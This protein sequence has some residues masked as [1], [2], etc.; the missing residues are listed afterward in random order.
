MLWLIDNC[1]CCGFRQCSVAGLVVVKSRKTAC[2]GNSAMG[3]DI[4]HE[5]RF[6]TH[7]RMANESG[8]IRC[9]RFFALTHAPSSHL[10]IIL[11][12][13]CCRHSEDHGVIRDASHHHGIG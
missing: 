6:A 2:G 7:G 8:T 9:G 12:N 11:S 10:R 4:G 5:V 1:R 13:Y 3:C